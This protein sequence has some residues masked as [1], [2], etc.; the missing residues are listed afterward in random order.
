MRSLLSISLSLAL[1]HSAM[2]TDYGINPPR[3]VLLEFFST[4]RCTNCPL[5][6]SNLERLFGDGGDSIIILDHHAGFYD[7]ALTIPESVEYEWF[8]NP[9]R[10]TYAPAAMFDRTCFDQQ[11]PDIYNEQVPMFDGSKASNLQPAYAQAASMPAQAE[12]M[13]IPTYDQASRKLELS[14]IG[15]TNLADDDNLR[16]NVFLAEDSIF[17]PTQVGAIGS[18][19]HRHAARRCLTDTW[20]EAVSAGKVFDCSY[21]TTLPDEWNA[22]RMEVVAFVSHYDAT[23]RR[24]CQVLNAAAEPIIA[25]HAD[26]RFYLDTDAS[27]APAELRVDQLDE[28]VI[29]YSR[30][31]G[32]EEGLNPANGK[33]TGWIICP[34]NSRRDVT[35]TDDYRAHQLRIKVDGDPIVQAGNYRLHIPQGVLNVYGSQNIVNEEATF[36]YIV[37]GANDRGEDGQLH[38]LSSYP[39]Q[40]ATVELPLNAITLNFDRDVTMRHSAFDAAGRITNLTSG[41]YIQ[42]SVQVEGPMVTITRGNF[43]STD[44][45]EGQQYELEIYEGRIK[46]A[47]D[48]TIVFPALTLGFS[49]AKDEDAQEALKVVAQIPAAG[50]NIRNAGSITFNRDITAVDASKVKLVNENGHEAKLSTVGRDGEAPRSLIFNIDPSEH[51]QG[52]TTYHLMLE[53]GA[54][55]AGQVA[56]QA[57]DAAYWC[58]PIERFSFTSEQ[59]NRAVPTFQSIVLSTD[60]AGITGTD[61]CH[62][63]RITGVATNQDHVYAQLADCRISG[64]DIT[65]EFDRLLTPEILAEGEALNNS[66]KVVIPEG[67]FTDADKRVNRQTEMIIYILEAKEIGP[68]T[69]TFNPASG[70]KVKQ[71][72]KAFVGTDADDKPLTTYSISFTVSGENVYARI[73]DASPLYIVELQSGQRVHSFQ[74]NDITGTR[75]SFSLELGD[76]AITADGIYQLVIPADAI[77]LYSDANQL[78]EPIHPDAD[79]TATWTI[80]DAAAI[81]HVASDAVTAA[82]AYD[83]WGRPTSGQGLRIQHRRIVVY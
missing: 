17:S 83:L 5:A 15:S 73:P 16:L 2:A 39:A 1:A 37:S 10:G 47:D 8:Y 51:L 63:I 34:D 7:D 56:C 61:L 58:I 55:M 78:T 4:E 25:R 43:S 19:Y 9:Y 38:L 33:G 77:L 50:Q 65:L 52:N 11:L 59:A 48:P 23:D 75:N 54:V 6:H 69:W 53:A 42:L 36:L 66:V 20:G 64:Q 12:I 41:G 71:L 40:G 81:Q 72:G 13:I 49:I 46:A 27:I 14:V 62:D 67:A 82:P 29:D 26:N 44:F 60:A 70:Q 79:V 3:R 30:C 35:F 68:Q 80:G 74:R 45:I 18:Y 24:R 31:P 21:T 22:R 76:Q 57:M 28:F 32:T